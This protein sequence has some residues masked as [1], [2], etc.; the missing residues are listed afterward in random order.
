MTGLFSYSWSRKRDTVGSRR[1]RAFGGGGSGPV[2]CFA[3]E[4]SQEARASDQ[5]QWWKTRPKNGEESRLPW[6]LGPWAEWRGV[7][8]AQAPIHPPPFAST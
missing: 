5:G 1:G 7:P 2:G 6:R 4:Q 3:V 8:Q